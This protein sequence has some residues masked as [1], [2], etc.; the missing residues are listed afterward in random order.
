MSTSI[1]HY[2]GMGAQISQWR[3]PE[4]VLAEAQK[5]ALA[6]KKVLDLK[7]QDKKVIFNK[8]E[9]LERED[10]GTVAKFYG[11]SAKSTESRFVQYGDVQGWEAVAV[12]VDTRTGVEVGRA[13]SMCLNDEDNWGQ[14]PVYEWVDELDAS[15]KKIWVEGKNGKK[16]YFKGRKEQKGSKP[17]PLF[18]LRSMAQT[19]AEAKALKSVFGWVVVLAGYR[20]TPAEEMTGREFDGREE[21]DEK[22]KAPIQDPQSK[23]QTQQSS[24]AQQSSQPQTQDFEG[25][26]EAVKQANSGAL[27]LTVKGLGLVK[28][29]VS[30]VDGDMKPG[31]FIQFHGKKDHDQRL[32]GDFYVFVALRELSEVQDGNAPAEKKLAPDL[33]EVAQEIFPDTDGKAAVQGMVED[34]TLK[35]ASQIESKVIGKKR[36]QRLYTLCT[37]NKDKNGGLNEELIKTQLL[38]AMVNP[39]QHLSDLETALYEKFENWATGKEDWKKWLEED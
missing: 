20:A 7:P 28:V 26:I 38:P 18:Q 21:Q 35:P 30:K 13:E 19:R 27:W 17:K 11:C 9:Y 31:Y 32:G 3:E 10:W 29:D 36:A 5:A 23:A 24:T 15:G 8:E 4:D 39:V 14:V 34:G 33:A 37:L 12:V 1:Q 25:V 2:E 16:G 6:L 22:K